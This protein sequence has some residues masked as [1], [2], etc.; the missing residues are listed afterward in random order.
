MRIGLRRLS[1]AA[2]VLALG[3]VA[4]AQ[5]GDDEGK[6]IQ[7]GPD[8]GAEAQGEPP[9]RRRGRVLQPGFREAP[10]AVSRYWIGV[11]G[12]PVPP[13]VRAHV[14]LEEGVGLLIARV[15]P[16]SPAAEGGLEQY[17]IVT[18]VD[19]D[20]VSDIR[21]LA[22][23]VGDV[24]ERKGRLTLQLLR[25]GRPRTLWV[26]PGEREIPPEAGRPN[27]EPW[28]G[29]FRGGALGGLGELP[30]DGSISITRSGDG[31]TKVLVRRGDESWEVDADDR[32]AIAA[33]PDDV[34]AL[35]ERALAT[36]GRPAPGLFEGS[37]LMERFGFEGGG[38][39]PDSAPGDL[40]QRLREMEEQV[41]QLRRRF[42]PPA[43]P[44][45]PDGDEAAIQPSA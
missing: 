42:E 13:E 9:R 23:A 28:R 31:S 38:G 35:V 20:P 18:R 16:G 8:R 12:G 5:S 32:E 25:E 37:R 24:G 10:R 45:R 41:E 39:L 21:Q 34:R 26:T 17:D 3:G 15:Q 27:A 43:E 6:L 44:P 14:R 1:I 33:L 30:G 22:E 19:G 29:G 11:A 4:A 2:A 36:G 7:I 40:Q